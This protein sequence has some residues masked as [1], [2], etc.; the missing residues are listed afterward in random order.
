M[1]LQK[2]INDRKEQES[3]L[4]SFVQHAGMAAP[5]KYGLFSLFLG[6]KRILE[7]K[8]EVVIESNTS[9][10]QFWEQFQNEVLESP[11]Y[12]FNKTISKYRTV[13]MPSTHTALF[14]IRT[15]TFT[16]KLQ[17]ILQLD[18]LRQGEREQ[19]SGWRQYQERIYLLNRGLVP[20]PVNY[21]VIWVRYEGLVVL[22]ILHDLTIKKTILKINLVKRLMRSQCSEWQHWELLK[23][24]SRTSSSVQIV[25]SGER[26]T[27]M[28]WM[29]AC[30]I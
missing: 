26:I 24:D 30:I 8:Q 16:K 22:T 13:I 20:C 9:L 2:T 3:G 15:C 5:R 29:N 12:Q 1:T 11:S 6:R 4:K 7:K 28:Y 10:T 21:N 18:N 14:P 25:S 27:F 19:V 17:L 23:C